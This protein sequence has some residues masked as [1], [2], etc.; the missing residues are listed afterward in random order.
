MSKRK[1]RGKY[2]SRKDLLERIKE[3]EKQLFG[4]PYNVIEMPSI[5]GKLDE[6]AFNKA[7]EMVQNQKFN[8]IDLSKAEEFI[9]P[10][11]NDFVKY[12]LYLSKHNK[13]DLEEGKC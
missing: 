1:N 13:I 4:I 10:R 5:I 2:K 6:E 7:L 8:D 12:W 11:G 9:V 3:L